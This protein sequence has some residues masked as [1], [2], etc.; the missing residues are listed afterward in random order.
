MCSCDTAVMRNDSDDLN[1]RESSSSQTSV[2]TTITDWGEV[3]NAALARFHHKHR[4]AE[5]L[6]FPMNDGR[7]ALDIIHSST[8]EYFDSLGLV[9]SHSLPWLNCG[10]PLLEERWPDSV[11]RTP[12]AQTMNAVDQIQPLHPAMIRIL[13]FLDGVDNDI[14]LLSPKSFRDQL[15]M[16]C[17]SIVMQHSGDRPNKTVVSFAQVARGSVEYWYQ[18]NQLHWGVTIDNSNKLAAAVQIDCGGYVYGWVSAVVIEYGSAGHLSSENES[19]R[20]LAGAAMAVNASCGGTVKIA[21]GIAKWV[22]GLW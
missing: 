21:R 17:D 1:Y 22:R 15:V 20:I 4:L 8:I 18:F 16:L 6:N 14:N 2:T 13:K 11:V 9:S 12:S 5:F 19:K 10:I 7:S 3:H